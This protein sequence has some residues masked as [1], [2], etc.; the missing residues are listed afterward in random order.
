MVETSRASRELAD[1]AD[2]FAATGAK[3]GKMFGHSGLLTAQ[4]KLIC[5]EHAGSIVFKLPPS[6]YDAVLALEGTG[7]FKPHADR[8]AMSNWIVVPERH[9]SEWPEL[10][11]ASLEYVAGVG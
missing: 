8:P 1:L 11:R 10:A 4:R 3:P 9:A 2:E 7:V 5:F 6:T